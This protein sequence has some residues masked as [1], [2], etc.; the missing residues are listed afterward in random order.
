VEWFCVGGGQAKP[1]I[2]RV[3]LGSYQDADLI[4]LQLATLPEEF[5]KKYD[6]RS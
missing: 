4:N 2:L 1:G 3:R 5:P 6:L